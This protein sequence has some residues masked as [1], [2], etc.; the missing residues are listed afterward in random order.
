MMRLAKD[1]RRNGME[2]TLVERD[3]H[4]QLSLRLL[5]IITPYRH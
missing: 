5:H 1:F 3:F 2:S 4:F